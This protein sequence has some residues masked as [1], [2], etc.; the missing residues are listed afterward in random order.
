MLPNYQS[1][2]N[3]GERKGYSGVALYSKENPKEVTFSFGDQNFDDE[4]RIIKAEFEN[5]TLFNIYFPNG[6]GSE[7]RLEYK[8]EFYDSFLN[9]LGEYIKIQP[10]IIVCGDVNTAHEEIDLAHP[11]QNENSSGF[12]KEE[13]EW[14]DKFLKLG[15]KDSFR[16]VNT[17][18]EQYSWWDMK[19]RSKREKYRLEN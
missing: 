14:I 5:F 4:G 17:S 10:N 3:S 9:N 2:F 13:R 6:G 19:T 1:F 8:M 7:K 12:L 18:A 15:F 16:M 11:K